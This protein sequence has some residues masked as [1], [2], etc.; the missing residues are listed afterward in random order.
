V[1]RSVILVVAP[2]DD[3]HAAEIVPR[4]SALGADVAQIDLARIPLETTLELAFARGEPER[5]ALH[6][7]GRRIDLAT[8]EAVWWRRPA[9]FAALDAISDPEARRFAQQ[10]WYAAFAGLWHAIPARWVNDPV[11]EDVAIRK[12]FQLATAA[13]A[14]LAVPRT[15][16]TSDPNAARAFA[17]TCGWSGDRVDIVVKTL[18]PVPGRYTHRLRT[19]EL[20]A[21][22][23]LRVAPAI[24][25]E[26]VDGVDL[27]VIIVGGA[28]FAMEVDA[29]R[30]AHPEDCRLDWENGRKTARVAQLPVGVARGLIATMD[31]LGLDYGAFDLRRRDDGEHVFLEVNP[32]GQWL[33]VE[34]ATGLPITDAVARL[35]AGR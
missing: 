4:L 7:R 13:R 34:E 14:G 33:Y 28:I 22:G 6:D 8:C 24:V 15:L 16:V 31:R 10:E 9:R 17:A 25:Q 26:Y 2:D 20:G 21:L 30:T 1:E 19:S 29:R 5:L 35:L 3:D 27:R 12:P 32:A 18:T 11:R 23:A